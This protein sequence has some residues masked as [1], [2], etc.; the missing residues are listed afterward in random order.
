M[1]IRVTLISHHLLHSI[2]YTIST[3][4]THVTSPFAMMS[5][6]FLSVWHNRSDMVEL[7]TLLTRWQHY[8]FENVTQKVFHIHYYY[9]K[10]FKKI[11]TFNNSAITI[12]CFNTTSGWHKGLF[13]PDAKQTL[14]YGQNQGSC[15]SWTHCY[16]RWQYVYAV[17]KQHRKTWILYSKPDFPGDYLF[18]TQ[19]GW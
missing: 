12:R 19:I 9:I 11:F 15:K 8:T 14:M 7:H 10:Y 1:C 18:H 13:W 5:Y 2:T 4:F 6:M 17:P 3:S 16:A